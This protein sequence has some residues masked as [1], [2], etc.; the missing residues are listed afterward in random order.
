[1]SKW[2]VR[3][4]ER[5]YMFVILPSA[6]ISTLHRGSGSNL[7][8][9]EGCLPAETLLHPDDTEL[10]IWRTS[11]IIDMNFTRSYTPCACRSRWCNLMTWKGKRT[12][13]RGLR[14]SDCNFDQARRAA[15]Q[16]VNL[17]CFQQSEFYLIYHLTHSVA[18][19]QNPPDQLWNVKCNDASLYYL[20]DNATRL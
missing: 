15:W 6:L 2:F 11:I 1:M 18:H 17:R 16:V 3:I 12:K 4:T 14:L 7:I 19:W 9:L 8:N 10:R 13:S 5:S 20:E